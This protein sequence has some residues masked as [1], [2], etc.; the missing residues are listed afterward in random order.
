[1]IANPQS[2]SFTP[3]EYLSWERQQSIKHEY[4]DGKVYAMTGG[5]LPHSDIA[6]NLYSQLRPHLRKRAVGLM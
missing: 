3:D 2:R 5:T 6:L 4:I 1:M